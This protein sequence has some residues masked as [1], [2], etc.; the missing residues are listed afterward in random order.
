MQS[1][2]AALDE[3]G[4]TAY[5]QVCIFSELNLHWYLSNHAV[6]RY[7]VFVRCLRQ[8]VSLRDKTLKQHTDLRDAGSCSIESGGIPPRYG[9]DW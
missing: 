6:R 5:E 2:L 1:K 3:E 4:L 7:C 9:L 8:C